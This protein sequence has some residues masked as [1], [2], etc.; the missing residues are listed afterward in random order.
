MGL[1]PIGLIGKMLLDALDPLNPRLL[2]SLLISDYELYWD[3]HVLLDLV[4]HHKN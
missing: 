3:L 1:A 2:T 4:K